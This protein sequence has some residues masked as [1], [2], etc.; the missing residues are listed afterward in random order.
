MKRLTLM[1]ILFT[2]VVGWSTQQVVFG[3]EAGISNNVGIGFENDYEPASSSEPEPKPEPVPEPTPK[4]KGISKVFP[5]TGEKM[6]RTILRLGLLLVMLSFLI[7][8][9]RFRQKKE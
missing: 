5:Q 6:G 9:S 1:A 4:P 7:I 2:L 8:I 3:E